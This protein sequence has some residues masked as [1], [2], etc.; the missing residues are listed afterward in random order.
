MCDNDTPDNLLTYGCHSRRDA[1]HGLTFWGIA[2]GA[3]VL[4]A[5]AA[6]GTRGA[7]PLEVLRPPGSVITTP[8]RPAFLS[9]SFPSSRAVSGVSAPPATQ[10]ASRP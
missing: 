4:V 9:A 6:I 7:T 10:K 8:A 5:F 2:I 1:E 3:V